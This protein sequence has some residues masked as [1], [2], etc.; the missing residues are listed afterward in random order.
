MGAGNYIKSIRE[1]QLIAAAQHGDVAARNE[2]IAACLPYLSRAVF[3]LAPA[4]AA[5]QR[6]DLLHEAVLALYDALEAYALDHPGRPRLYV[7][8]STRI[9]KAVALYFRAYGAPS[10]DPGEFP[11]LE[12]TSTPR[13]DSAAETAEAVSLVRAGLSG[14]APFDTQV[15]YS[16]LALDPPPPRAML[17]RQFGC[18][19][20]WIERVERRAAEN[21]A[22][23]IAHPQVLSSAS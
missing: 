21:F 17:A 7:F 1:R 10:V 20:Q 16:R 23:L 9:R 18:S 15:L 19:Q 12:D 3:A 22:D 8:A 11:E 13:P 4:A 14:L 6:D 2:L 5:D